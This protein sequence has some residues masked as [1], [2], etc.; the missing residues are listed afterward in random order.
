[1]TA[2]AL[3]TPMEAE[4][5]EPEPLAPHSL[6]DV[7]TTHVV[8][9]PPDETAEEEERQGKHPRDKEALEETHGDDEGSPSKGASAFFYLTASCFIEY[10]FYIFFPSTV[11]PK[12]SAFPYVSGRENADDPFPLEDLPKGKR[13][14]TA[15]GRTITS[16]EGEKKHGSTEAT[17][18]EEPSKETTKENDNDDESSPTARHACSAA[19]LANRFLSIPSS[20]SLRELQKKVAQQ[21]QGSECPLQASAWPGKVLATCRKWEETVA[22][23]VKGAVGEAYST[24]Q[25]LLTEGWSVLE[26]PLVTGVRY[27][28]VPVILFLLLCSIFTV[29]LG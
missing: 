5:G 1:M 12:P 17:E 4:G 27:A 7:S 23:K 18:G 8:P 21:R 20:P 25:G 16:S 14:V 28:G 29:M 3:H 9:P 2:K 26:S 6:S 19:A 15:V 10:L 24:V 11:F 13:V 22:P